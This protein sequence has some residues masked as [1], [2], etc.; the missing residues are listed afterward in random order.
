MDA[1]VGHKLME[2][3]ARDL[4]AH[5]VEARKHNGFGCVVD[6]D[7]DACRG[8]EGTDV[9][10]FAADDAAFDLVGVDMEHCHRVFD[11][12]F[13]RHTLNALDNNAFCF[14]VGRHLRIVHDVVDIGCGGSL[15][16]VFERLDE[17]FSGFV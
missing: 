7:L 11:G 6:D 1:A 4:A 3:E 8:F 15:C 2:R 14:L 5:G 17:F 12:G 16:L 10:A 13:C 9:A